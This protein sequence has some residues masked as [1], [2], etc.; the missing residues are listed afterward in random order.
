MN[1][2]QAL[3][4]LEADQGK[5]FDLLITDVLMPEMGGKELADAYLE[6]HPEGKV[7]FISGFTDEIFNWNRKSDERCTFLMKPFEKNQLF[8]AIHSILS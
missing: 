1:G 6:M 8:H 4:T 5:P 3:R 7:V 2:L